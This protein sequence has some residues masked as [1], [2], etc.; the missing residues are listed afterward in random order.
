M[1]SRTTLIAAG[2]LLC[3]SGIGIA[4]ERPSDAII[5]ETAALETCTEAEVRAWRLIRVGQARLALQDCS[6]IS[7][8]FEAPL[9]L[10][11]A[12]SRDVPGHAFAESAMAMLERNLDPATFERFK[13]RF[14]AFNSGYRDTGDGDAYKLHLGRQGE[15]VLTF[16]G[17]EIAREQGEDFA[18]AYMS[19]WFGE[20]PFSRPLRTALLG[21]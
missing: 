17:E 3:L 19:I 21:D 16:N 6:R 7:H 11:F 20:R 2:L 1:D 10:T 15:F 18:N 4:G 12:Y 9:Q 14:Q 8:P 5:D 13:E